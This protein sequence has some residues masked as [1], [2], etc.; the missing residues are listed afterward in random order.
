[1]L[2][3]TNG[4]LMSAETRE[5]RQ[6]VQGI[7]KVA[8]SN[9][10]IIMHQLPCP[11]DDRMTN[12]ARA[13]SRSVQSMGLMAAYDESIKIHVEQSLRR[14]R[15][16]AV[17]ASEK[18]DQ[19]V[20]AAKVEY[21]AARDAAKSVVD[22]G[23]VVIPIVGMEDHWKIIHDAKAAQSAFMDASSRYIEAVC[24][25]D[26]VSQVANAERARERA[27]FEVQA[28]HAAA[29]VGRVTRACAMSA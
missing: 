19:M 16:N 20:G 24:N 8:R 17:R 21:D 23:F 3:Y 6:F 22:A 10:Y 28:E 14:S 29:C 2:P 12:L 7:N 9:A 26:A 13:A 27:Y 11:V 25:R 5:W 18:A 1:M 4:T 15:L